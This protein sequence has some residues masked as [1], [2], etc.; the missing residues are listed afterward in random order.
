MRK[1]AFLSGL[2]RTGSTVLGTLLSQHPSLYPTSTSIVRDL[3]NTPYRFHLGESPF[4]NTKDINSPCWNIMRGIMT[5]AYQH[6]E[7]DKIVVEKDRGW[8]GNISKLSKLIQ[9]KPKIIA[10][11]RP[12]EEIITSFILLSK[13]I[14]RKS[15]IDDEVR[16]LNRDMDNTNRAR[17]IWEKYVYANWKTFKI[18]YEYDPS[19]F[20]LL[21]YEDITSHPQHV[22]DKISSFLE[23]DSF[24][25]KTS[26]L[27]NPRPE[28]DEV[29]G[30]P[31]LH[32]VRE[33]LKRTSPPAEEV[34][35]KE[36]CE[37]WRQKRLNFWEYDPLPINV[38]ID[39]PKNE[40]P[41]PY[42]LTIPNK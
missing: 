29:Y 2:P 12:V 7:E 32:Q 24:K 18:G 25:V 11:V 20:L 13:K 38:V 5:G 26:G 27:Y 34:L 14:G 3:T 16:A 30:L 22:I 40:V 6:V 21:N 35:G 36:L 39:P 4:Y 9:D 19:C 33:E 15:K 37:T 17:I 8:A 28:N 31:G 1:F 42:T 23:V 10:T 41:N